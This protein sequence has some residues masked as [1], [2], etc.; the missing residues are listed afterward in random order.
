[1]TVSNSDIDHV[2]EATVLGNG[3]D[4]L[5]MVIGSVNGRD[6]VDTS[7]KTVADGGSQ[8]TVVSG[9]IETLEEGEDFR[10]QG[11]G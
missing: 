4:S 10:I 3:T 7:W 1:M 5:L 2:V 6:T 11:L 8:Y 9:I